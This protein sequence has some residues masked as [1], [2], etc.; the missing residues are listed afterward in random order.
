MDERNKLSELMQ[1]FKRSLFSIHDL[2]GAKLLSRLSLG[3]SYLNKHKF[4]HSFSDTVTPMSCT[5]IAF[6]LK[7]LSP[8]IAIK[9]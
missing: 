7:Y 9:I 5:V 6:L 3:F 4:R 2:V 1:A 8:S